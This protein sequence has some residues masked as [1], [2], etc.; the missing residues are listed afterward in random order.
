[1]RQ[2]PL[3]LQKYMK[4]KHKSASF[5]ATTNKH[6][7]KLD[8]IYYI[9]LERRKDREVHFLQ[10]CKQAGIRMEIL[11]KFVAIDGKIFEPTVEQNKM[12]RD[13][14]YK[15]SPFCKNIM[16][17]QLSHY[18]ILKDMIE[19]SYD[20]ILILQDD[21]VF[22]KNFTIELDHVL[23]SLP[24]DAEIIN[25]GIHKFAAFADFVP[26]DLENHRENKTPSK[27]IINR[28]ICELKDHINPC[29]LAY[30]ITKKGCHNLVQYFQIHGFRDPTDLNYNQYLQERRINYAST[31]VLCTGALLGSDVW[32]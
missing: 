28:F 21:V 9:N 20:C 17:N 4:H 3:R 18:Y 11:Q 7:T 27:R 22:K 5:I 16:A 31:N 19:K 25:I 14:T 23:N 8:R 29:S 6:K 32:T 30:I 10:Q 26:I 13:C 1:M 12:F 15:N 24:E 2:M